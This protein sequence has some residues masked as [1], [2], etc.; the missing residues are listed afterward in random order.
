MQ[1]NGSQDPKFQTSVVCLLFRLQWYQVAFCVWRSGGTISALKSLC[2]TYRLKEWQQAWHAYS[3]SKKQ[4]KS[5]VYKKL[6]WI[7][8]PQPDNVANNTNEKDQNY[9]VIFYLAISCFFDRSKTKSFCLAGLEVKLCS[10]VSWKC[11]KIVDRKLVFCDENVVNWL[12]SFWKLFLCSLG[13]SAL[14]L[15]N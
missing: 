1:R 15:Q 4:S 13:M 2:M 11:Q 9:S 3:H 10:I 7:Y 6:T 5:L 8:L 12:C 14:L